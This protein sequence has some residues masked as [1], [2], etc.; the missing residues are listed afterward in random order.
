M[1]TTPISLLF[2]ASGLH[3]AAAAT[4]IA[5]NSPG[6]NGMGGTNTAIPATFGDNITIPAPG[7]AAFQTAAGA[8]G[9]VGTPDINLT[10]S[11]TGGTNANRWEFHAWTGAGGGALQM[12]GSSVGSVFSITFTPTA[13]TAVVL[14]S[15]NFIGDTNS[16]NTYLYRVDVVD[17]SDSSVVS[18]LTTAEWNTI[19]GQPFNNAPAVNVGFTGDLGQA[20]RLDIVRLAGTGTP[21]GNVDIAIDNLSFDQVP[22]PATALLGAFGA[23][24]LLRRRR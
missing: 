4:I 2:L 9:T 19:T 10:W 8:N 23:L 6:S 22:E 7:N 13:T 21:A 1:K 18:T 12:D 24:T 5:A 11:A 20:Y 16:A 15:F 14:D 17:L 3:E